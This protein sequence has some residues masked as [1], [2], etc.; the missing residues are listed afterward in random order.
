MD[1]YAVNLTLT[2]LEN[3]TFNCTVTARIIRPVLIWVRE[4]NILPKHS[5]IKEHSSEVQDPTAGLLY[6]V[7]KKYEGYM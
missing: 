3:F 1:F 4:N 2:Q 6:R 5:T 7:N